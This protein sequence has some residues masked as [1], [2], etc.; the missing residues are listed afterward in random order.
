[1]LPITPSD[2]TA[3][4]A[5]FLADP[6]DRLGRLVFADWLE[7]KGGEA[8]ELWARYLR[9]MAH[10]EEDFDG[11]F[12]QRAESL[13]RAVRARLTLA[14]PPGKSLLPWL[15]AFLPAHRIWVR[16]GEVRIQRS[17]VDWCP[18]SVA[19]RYR[20]IPIEMIDHRL[21]FVTACQ[22]NQLDDMRV[23]LVFILNRQVELL[24]GEP[25]DVWQAINSNFGVSMIDHC[26]LE[27]MS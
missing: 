7:E 17:V 9:Y 27:S 14:A 21:Y 23:A 11:V 16:L 4:T 19:R 2:A 24:R 13:G 10:A 8:N 6:A 22:V 26:M 1:V 20:A 25:D 12:R 3:F 5:R 15:S 18:E